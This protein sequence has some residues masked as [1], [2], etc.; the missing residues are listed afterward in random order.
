MTHYLSLETYP[1]S[2]EPRTKMYTSAKT[3]IDALQT[4]SKN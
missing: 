3:W 4:T 2:I 1:Y